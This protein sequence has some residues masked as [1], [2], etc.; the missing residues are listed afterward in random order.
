MQSNK[1]FKLVY[2]ALF[3][4]LIFVG[5]QFLQIPLPFGYFNFGDCFIVLSALIIGGPYAI[6]ASAAGA[7]LADVLSGYTVY[8]PATLIIK[9]IMVVSITAT[10][11]IGVK[12]DVKH[13]TMPV[14]LGAVVAELIM[15]LGYFVYDNILYNFAGAVAALPGNIIQ[16]VAAVVIS[17]VVAAVLEHA[18][19]MKTIKS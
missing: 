11:R 19:L 18:G 9:A 12:A 17:T 4:A 8:A 1:T 6:M 10:I 14:I 13:K 15:V 7:A 5:T 16:G 3:A 2:C